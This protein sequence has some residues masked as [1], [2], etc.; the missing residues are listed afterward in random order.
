MPTVFAH[1][2]NIQRGTCSAC[3][4]LPASWTL[5]A[6]VGMIGQVKSELCNLCLS[7]FD[8]PAWGQMAEQQIMNNLNKYVTEAMK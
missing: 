2:S 8:I 4:D 1:N 7:R 3:R 6:Q 5:T